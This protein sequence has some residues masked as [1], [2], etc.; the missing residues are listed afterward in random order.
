LFISSENYK[1]EVEKVI[2]QGTEIDIAVAFWGTGAAA[3]LTGT[4][5]HF[6]VLCNLMTGGTNPAEIEALRAAGH[7]L[8]DLEDLHAK[9][10]VSEQSAI[11]GSANFS[12][13]G[14]NIQDAEFD[15]WQEAG[16]VTDKAEDLQQIRAW[17]N[18][19]WARARIITPQRLAQARINWAKR[20]AT[21]IPMSKHRKSVLSMANAELNGRNVYVALWRDDP[22]PEAHAVA[23]EVIEDLAAAQSSKEW[24][25]FEDWEGMEVGQTVISIYVGQRG[26]VKVDGAYEIF[27]VLHRIRTQKYNRGEPMMLH[28]C[29]KVP[30]VLDM[31][32][33]PAD[34]TRLATLVRQAGVVKNYLAEGTVFLPLADFL[35]AIDNTN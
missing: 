5:K 4:G 1:P 31:R 2:A 8:L 25:S 34:C 18:A 32:F 6:R 13:N 17:F 9:V 35:A 20:C 22:S 24:D 21:R 15:G 28:I 12:T 16:Y 30:E 19:Q 33:S 14:L 10:V 11:V 23:A 26:R 27:E 29:F 7:E 3:L